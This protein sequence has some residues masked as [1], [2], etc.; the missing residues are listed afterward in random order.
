MAKS[1]YGIAALIG[2]TMLVSGCAYDGYSQ[3]GYDRGSGRH[4]GSYGHDFGT[5]MAI[6]ATTDMLTATP[7][8]SPVPAQ[9][10]SIHGSQKRVK[11]SS[12]FGTIMLSARAVKSA[13]VSPRAS[14]ASS[15]AGQIPTVIIS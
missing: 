3:G 14:T 8:I 10:T 12:L 11:D 1:R 7:A 15:A 4:H 2:T 6:V 5:V 13:T 9:I